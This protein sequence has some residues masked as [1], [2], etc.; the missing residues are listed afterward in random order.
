MRKISQ[1]FLLIIV[2]TLIVV[3][4]KF[5]WDESRPQVP[6]YEILPPQVGTIE[7]T[8][9]ATGNIEPRNKIL[10]KPQISGIII[11]I[12]QEAGESIN[13]DEIIAEVKVTTEMEK[14]SRAESGVNI[15]K[16][17]LD[18]VEQEHF[19]QEILF[20][21]GVIAKN[22]FE[23]STATYQRAL[24]EY[25][26]AKD[27]LD[28]A[29]YG[30]S[31]KLSAI[32]NTQIRSTISGTVL[33]IPVKEGDYV[34]QSNVFN[35]GTTIATVADMSD[36]IFKGTVDETEVGLL[37]N[38]MPVKIKIAA[39]RNQIFDANITYI[40]PQGQREN[41]T[42]LYE[43]K[44]TLQIP[45]AISIRSDYSANAEIVIEQAK[46]V[47]IVPESSVEFTGDSSF[48]YVL[49]QQENKQTFEKRKVSIG[50][51]DGLHIEIKEG[52]ALEEKIRGVE[53]SE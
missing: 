9:I 18:Q 11:K 23:L 32:S 7:N 13:K 21:K 37:R 6:A 4:F 40:A 45:E 19:R 10:I 36:L 17:N 47:V 3:T 38:N 24:E 1:V 30:V 49:K 16:I 34:I 51:S 22:E 14:L 15:A 48:V 35:E 26:N 8:V 27:A 29:R 52:I 20:Q 53:L 44:A 12:D 39:I 46:D 31:E 50:L 5:L 41:G 2:I 42:V 28:I 33:E 43:I 25:S